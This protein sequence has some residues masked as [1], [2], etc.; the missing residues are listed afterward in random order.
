MANNTDDK[1]F[2]PFDRVERVALYKQVAEQIK[3]AILKGIYA[4][5]DRLPS[6]RELSRAF[7]VGRPTIR[8]ALKLVS[9]R[10]LIELNREYR[11][12]VVKS[13]GLD[14][15]IRPVREQISWFLDVNEKNIFDFWEVIPHFLGITAHSAIYREVDCRE[16]EDYIKNMETVDNFFE[17][18]KFTYGFG[19]KLAELTG[20][21]VIIVIWKTLKN[22]I[23]KE[24]PPIQT[25]VEPGGVTR[26]VEYHKNILSAIKTNDHTAVDR[27]V[28]ERKKYARS[29][30]V[31]PQH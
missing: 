16:L 11:G 19:L 5:G 26:L 1:Q 13:P 4:P 3:G 18:S 27:A 23:T 21:P 29:L 10:G 14:A 25:N 30:E 28:A 2:A 31:L 17:L 12:Y 7:G 20:N 22:V 8:E 9:N 24:F 15:Y 6:E